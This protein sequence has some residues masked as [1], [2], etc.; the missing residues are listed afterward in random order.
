M[1]K[2]FTDTTKWTN[3]KWFFSLSIESK[4]FW[5]Y[6]LDAC[7]NVGV[8]EENVELASKIIGYTYPLDTLLKDF[9]K[10]IHI[11]KDNRK[12]WIID[13]CE[14]Q[15]GVFNEESISKPIQSYISALK[16]HGLWKPYLK[17]I[18]TLK[19]KE[20]D[21]DK[22]MDKEKEKEKEGEKII[23]P[24]DDER[25]EQVW[26]FWKKYKKEQH[27]F[28]YKPIGEQGAL[29]KLQ[30]LSDGKLETAMLIIKQSIQNGWAGL[31]ELKGD[32]KNKNKDY[33]VEEIYRNI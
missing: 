9:E 7:D 19:E 13:F 8:W 30:E 32:F 2:R 15:Y 11:F 3:N 24:W 1:A 22:D 17:G 10:Q 33:D 25:F 18:H 27:R 23:L 29:S 21:K 20:K 14:F 5:I 28:S 31:F 12:W 16:K 26:E 4:L 6:L